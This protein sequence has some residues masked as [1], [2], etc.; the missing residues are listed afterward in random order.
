MGKWQ[1]IIEPT[2]GD[3]IVFKDGVPQVSDT[4]IIPFLRGDG[5]GPDIWAAS[6]PVLDA[7]VELTSGGKRR[8]E[9]L[10]VYAG[11]RAQELYGEYLPAETLD[12][13]RQYAVAIKG[14]LTTP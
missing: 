2:H 10:E 1:H 11:E 4:P 12:A 8:I 9:W 6:Q 14:P 13:L 3:T 5:I 7:A